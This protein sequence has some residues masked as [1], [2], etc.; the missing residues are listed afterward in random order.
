MA[1]MNDCS[2]SLDLYWIPLGAGDRPGQSVVRFS[3]RVFEAVTAMF[4]RRPRQP[5]FHAALVATPDGSP[6]YVEMA[7]VPDGNGRD[8]RG[9]V[10]EGAVGT[11]WLGRL[12]I[13][14]Y[15]VRRWANGTIPD[16]VSYTHLRAHE[17]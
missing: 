14:R 8:A 16:P 13:F 15:E 3:G 1:C 9:V 11:H 4:D 17:T 2:M 10:A 12:R 5:L 7:P 6:V